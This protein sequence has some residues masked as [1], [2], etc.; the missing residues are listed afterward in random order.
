MDM[1]YMRPVEFSFYYE[2]EINIIDIMPKVLDLSNK[3]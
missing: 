2:E 1:S 3:I